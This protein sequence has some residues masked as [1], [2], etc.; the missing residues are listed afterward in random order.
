MPI[1]ETV[2]EYI[3]ALKWPVL[4]GGVVFWER[5]AIK[6]A[7]EHFRMPDEGSVKV[8]GLGDLSWKNAVQA[9][10]EKAEEMVEQLQEERK[11]EDDTRELP[12]QGVL[13]VEMDLDDTEVENATR[14]LQASLSAW[15]Q[16]R[17]EWSMVDRLVLTDPTG[18]V[19]NAWETLQRRLITKATKYD[20]PFSQAELHSAVHLAS[21]MNMPQELIDVITQLRELRNSVAHAQVKI[22]SEDALEYVQTVKRLTDRIATTYWI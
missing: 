19:I 15:H 5:N 9:V 3:Q 14:I 21:K 17:N 2:L 18:A 1:P 12:T 16:E 4:V 8:T 10:A 13:R 22:N 20:L 6:R 11:D 7:I